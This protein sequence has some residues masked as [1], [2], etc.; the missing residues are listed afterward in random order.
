MIPPTAT[1]CYVVLAAFLEGRW[2]EV[3]YDTADPK[4][5]EAVRTLKECGKNFKILYK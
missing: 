4:W 3:E 1:A 2:I 5:R